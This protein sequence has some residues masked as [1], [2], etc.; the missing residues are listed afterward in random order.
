MVSPLASASPNHGKQREAC[1]GSTETLHGNLASTRSREGWDERDTMSASP[2][3]LRCD[4]LHRGADATP[5]GA[6]LVQ[7]VPASPRHRR[8]PGALVEASVAI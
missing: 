2:T 8:P 6:A 4:V 7:L 5:R 3:V 1:H